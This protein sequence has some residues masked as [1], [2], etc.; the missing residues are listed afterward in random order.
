MLSVSQAFMFFLYSLI[1]VSSVYT[2]YAQKIWSNPAWTLDVFCELEIISIPT[3]HQH[4]VETPNI[5][6]KMEL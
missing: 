1:W 3:N 4:I 2:R 6:A 5:T